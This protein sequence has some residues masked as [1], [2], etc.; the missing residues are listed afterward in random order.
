MSD[1]VKTK[2]KIYLVVDKFTNE[3]KGQFYSRIDAKKYKG[4]ITGYKYSHL[5][6]RLK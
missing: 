1:L 4:A 2:V 6:I 5:T 3:V